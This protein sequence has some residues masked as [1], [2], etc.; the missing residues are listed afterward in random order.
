LKLHI[1]RSLTAAVGAQLIARKSLIGELEGAIQSGSREK[2]LETLRRVT[3]LFLVDSERLN[4]EQVG[5]FDEVLS[6]LISR[7]EIKARVELGERL[8]PIENA[9][10]E[11]IRKLA[12]DEEIAVAAPVLAQSHS[13]L[14]PT[15]SLRS[16][17][18]GARIICS[19]SP[20]GRP[21]KKASRTFFWSAETMRSITGS[22][23]IQGRF[24]PMVATANSSST[25]KPTAASRRSLD[26]AW[27]FHSGSS[28]N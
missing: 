16:R 9:P 12:R 20:A 5:V 11:T 22:Q 19:R 3:D 6:Q 1:D 7:I 24:F 25:Q 27:I 28:V 10:I 13:A 18:P 26:C 23:R 17:A 14:T 15:I 2:R 21:S 4:E 8:A